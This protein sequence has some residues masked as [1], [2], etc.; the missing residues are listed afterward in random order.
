VPYKCKWYTGGIFFTFQSI[1]LFGQNGFLTGIVHKATYYMVRVTLWAPLKLIWKE[2]S[3]MPSTVHKM[4]VGGGRQI[5]SRRGLSFRIWNCRKMCY[6]TYITPVTIFRMWSW[7]THI[8]RYL[9]HKKLCSKRELNGEEI[10][11]EDNR[12]AGGEAG[13][14]STKFLWFWQPHL[15]IAVQCLYNW[16]MLRA[17]FVILGASDSLG[18]VILCC[19]ELSCAL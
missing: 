4:Q 14:A 19:G 9:S 15:C 7:K 6:T 16:I 11:K 5:S 13:L 8:V 3:R 12:R 18:Q 10:D 1:S 2:Q 17:G